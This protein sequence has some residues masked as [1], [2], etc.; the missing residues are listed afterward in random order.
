MKNQPEDFIIQTRQVPALMRWRDWLL[1]LCLWI[2][3]GAWLVTFITTG[4]K[5]AAFHTGQQMADP[6]LLTTFATGLRWAALIAGTIITFNAISGLFNLSRIQR[7][8]R[9]PPTPPLLVD[10]QASML[11]LPIQQFAAWR[12][13][14]RLV[15]EFDEHDQ[16]TA[17]NG[18][19]VFLRRPGNEPAS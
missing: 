15:L 16:L 3:V 11:G 9:A 5:Q 18:L 2:L 7:Q 12:E 1:T 13:A 14:P 6:G 4:T 10:E 17:I 8:H 19:P